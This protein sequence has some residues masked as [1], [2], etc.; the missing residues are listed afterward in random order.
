VFEIPPDPRPTDAVTFAGRQ[1]HDVGNVSRRWYRPAYTLLDA[2]YVV[3]A[4]HHPHLAPFPRNTT[5]REFDT[6][7][8]VNEHTGFDYRRWLDT[9]DAFCLFLYYPPLGPHGD[10][11]TYQATDTRVWFDH[12]P[13]HGLPYDT[14]A[15]STFTHCSAGDLR[16][17]AWEHPPHRRPLPP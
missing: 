17:H 4:E 6:P 8:R 5:G 3:A 15:P 9:Y 2:T 10:Q 11:P 12:L 1:K 14:S 16:P 13:S 7:Y